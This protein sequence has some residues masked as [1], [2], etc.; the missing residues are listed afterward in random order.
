MKVSR[1]HRGQNGS[2]GARFRGGDIMRKTG[3]V[4]GSD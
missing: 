4:V 2:A 3:P 1:W